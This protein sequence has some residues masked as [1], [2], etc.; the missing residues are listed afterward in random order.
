MAMSKSTAARA[1]TFFQ[2]DID[3]GFNEKAFKKLP[4]IYRNRIILTFAVDALPGDTL[5]KLKSWMETKWKEI[6]SDG[7][8]AFINTT[9]AF[10]RR[11]TVILGETGHYVSVKV[12]FMRIIIYYIIRVIFSLKYSLKFF[13]F[14]SAE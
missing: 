8:K 13:T 10:L 12:F 5:A 3:P 4:E 7:Q 1:E 2:T 11:E 14:C 9:I 6:P